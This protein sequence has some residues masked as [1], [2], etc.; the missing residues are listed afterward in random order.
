MIA[1]REAAAREA[2]A[3]KK[4]DDETETVHRTVRREQELMHENEQLRSESKQAVSD[5]ERLRAA[6]TDAAQGL[7]NEVKSETGQARSLRLDI[8]LAEQREQL[9][10]Q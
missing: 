6:S 1:E 8:Q 7:V 10:K 3:I 4:I 2:A 9:M 5:S